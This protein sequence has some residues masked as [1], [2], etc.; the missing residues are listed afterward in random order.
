MSYLRTTIVNT[1][2][3]N[4]RK[5]APLFVAPRSSTD[6]EDID[7]AVELACGHI[8]RKTTI[9]EATHCPMCDLANGGFGR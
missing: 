1:L 7:N 2:N 3:G 9:F 4:D 5:I 8:V 6:E